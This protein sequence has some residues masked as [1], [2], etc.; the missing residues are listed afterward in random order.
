M[1]SRE[2]IDIIKFPI[3]T[4]KTTKLLAGYQYTFMV[5]PKS[6]KTDIKNA[7][8]YLFDVRVLA[9]N[10]SNL[11]KKEKKVGKFLG[12]RT[13]YKKSIVTLM[14]GSVLSLFLEI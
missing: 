1:D 9:V 12:F 11:P 5:A 8:E 13:T 3:V 14:P 7:I 4:D 10:T 2:L 6:T